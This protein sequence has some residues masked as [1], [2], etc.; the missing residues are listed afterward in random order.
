MV[1]RGY[2]SMRYGDVSETAGVPITSLQHHFPTLDQLRREALVHSVRVELDAVTG[3]V[4]AARDPWRRLDALVDSAVGGPARRR[5]SFAPWLTVWSVAGRDPAIA[6]VSAE[7]T[8]EWTALIR[9]VVASGV[10]AKSFAPDGSLDQT[11]EQLRSFIAG[12]GVL[13]SAESFAGSA[14]Q[15]TAAAATAAATAARIVGAKKR[16]K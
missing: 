3:E 16:K 5:R 2:E 11:T 12:L 15:A 4:G 14:K 6:E 10:S 7:L 13:A 8:A 9:S 1:E